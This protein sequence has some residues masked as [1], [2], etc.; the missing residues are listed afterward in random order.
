M[1]RV[2]V[3]GAGGGLGSNVVRVAI[4]RG[5]A[6][7]ALVRDPKKARLAAGAELVA[8]DALDAESIRR[9]LEGCDALL[10]MVNV[11]F[12]KAWI[13]TT[14]RLLEAAIDAC[15]STGARLVFPANVWIY[16]RGRP[17]VTLGEDAPPSPCSAKGAARLRKEERLRESGVRFAAV[18]LPEFYG[19]HVQ[20]LTGPPLRKLVQGKTAVWWGPAD[21]PAEFV[22]MPDAARVLLDVA[23][24]DGVDG[25]T[26][27]LPGVEPTTA[28]AFFEDARRQTG[29]GTFRVMPSFIVKGA[30]LVYP[31][32]REF[33]DVLHLWE[34]PILLD[35]AKLRARFPS[36]R[37]TPYAEGI[38]ETLAWLRANPDVPM[39][40]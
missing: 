16:G 29:T 17:G 22:F 12:D 26:F 37:S 7:R 40:F 24:A 30:G 31:M 15:T 27:H 2:L 10:H 5:L 23:L 11:G 4:E 6:V 25:E 21:L 13:A 33:A 32:A 19:P 36:V 1:T 18:R 8:G 14:A 34:A 20:T 35:G 3:T 39:Y 38:T 28:R 9:A